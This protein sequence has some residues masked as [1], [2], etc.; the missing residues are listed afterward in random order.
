MR[1]EAYFTTREV[2]C[3]GCAGTRRCQRCHGRG[4][5]MESAMAG[6]RVESLPA[7]PRAMERDVIE[8]TRLVWMDT[9]ER[10]RRAGEEAASALYVRD[11]AVRERFRLEREARADRRRGDIWAGRLILGFAGWSSALTLAGMAVAL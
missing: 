5:I 3:P 4:T 11:S 7:S 2:E 10:L 9:E 1:H 6:A 8:V